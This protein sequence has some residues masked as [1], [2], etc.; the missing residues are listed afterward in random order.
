M[1]VVDFCNKA[2]TVIEG[3][4]DLQDHKTNC[5]PAIARLNRR[6]PKTTNRQYRK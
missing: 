5:P 1:H 2:T 4:R 6:R 3:V